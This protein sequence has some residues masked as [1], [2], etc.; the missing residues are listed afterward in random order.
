MAFGSVVAWIECRSADEFEG[1]FVAE[2]VRRTPATR[3]YGTAEDAR[4]WVEQEAAFIAAPV[5]WVEAAPF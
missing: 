4:R 2:A 3:T 5:K 1:A